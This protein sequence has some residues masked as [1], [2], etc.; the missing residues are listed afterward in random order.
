MKNNWLK[1]RRE[2][3]GIETQDEFALRLQLEGIN[4]SRAA[5]SHWENG[6]NDPPLDDPEFRAVLARILKLSPVEILRLAGYE[7]MTPPHTSEAE[8]AAFIL[9]Q[10]TNERDRQLALAILEQFLERQP[11]K[12]A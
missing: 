11:A 9:D 4:I 6:R 1:Q 5:I 12:S 10:L 7:V 2:L 8:R 3:V